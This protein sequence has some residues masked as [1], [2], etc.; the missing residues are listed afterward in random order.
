[1]SLELNMKLSAH[2][3]FLRNDVGIGGGNCGL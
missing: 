2:E 3:N 1:M